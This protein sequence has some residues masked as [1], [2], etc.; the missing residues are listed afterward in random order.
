M[1]IFSVEVT[2]YKQHFVFVC[3]LDLCFR[4][5]IRYVVVIEGWANEQ[6]NKPA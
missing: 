3:L 6:F 1:F 4:H 5:R 2:R